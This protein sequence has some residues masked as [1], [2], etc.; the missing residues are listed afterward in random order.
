MRR[1]SYF[2]F[3]IDKPSARLLRRPLS[4]LILV[5]IP[6]HLAK[7]DGEPASQAPFVTCEAGKTTVVMEFVVVALLVEEER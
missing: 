5:Y 3:I 1:C 4:L 7:G 6:P 2:G